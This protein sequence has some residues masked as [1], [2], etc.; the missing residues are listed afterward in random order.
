MSGQLSFCAVICFS[1]VLG[2]GIIFS[3]WSSGSVYSVLGGVRGIVQFVSYEVVYSFLFFCLFL[4]R[5]GFFPF[6]FTL[7]FRGIG[8]ML[9]FGVFLLFVCASLAERQRS[10]FDFSEGERELVR[11]FNTEFSSF[12]F[13]MIFL[14]EYGILSFV[15]MIPVCCFLRGIRQ[16]FV[17]LVLVML[18]SFVI[19]VRGSLPRLRFDILQHLA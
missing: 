7:R 17:G 19:I 10:P 11:G 12:Y 9:F 8:V 16:L 5:G 18:G 2:L 13:S 3:G 6:S 14:T 1:S 4:I 15:L